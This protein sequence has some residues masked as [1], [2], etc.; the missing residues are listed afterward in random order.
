MESLNAALIAG[1]T[2]RYSALAA[3][4]RELA[5]QISDEQFWSKP[6]SFGNSFGHLVLHLTG[7]LNY[8]IG[9]EI[10]GTGYVRDRPREFTEANR[11]SKEEALRKFD[12]A[13]AVV[14]RT[15]SSQS[16]DDWTKNYTAAGESDA[17]NR[18]TIF[19]RCA[20]HLHHHVGQMMYLCFALNGRE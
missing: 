20:T 11:P 4:V 2:E 5:G 6:F 1:L 17:S 3:K 15:L 10:G 14:L 13:V 9:A 7:N 16:A 19:L 18:M 12:E 8:Y